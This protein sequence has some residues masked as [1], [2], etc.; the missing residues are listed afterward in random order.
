MV[1]TRMDLKHKTR[2]GGV[3]WLQLIVVNL[4]AL[5]ISDRLPASQDVVHSMEL[6]I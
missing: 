3:D 6:I 2:Y 1:D 5:E 4:C